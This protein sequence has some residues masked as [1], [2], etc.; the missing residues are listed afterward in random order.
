MSHHRPKVL[1]FG[2]YRIF[3]SLALWVIAPVANGQDIGPQNLPSQNSLSPAQPSS[4]PFD[5]DYMDARA[6]TLMQQSQ[7]TG[8]AMA[9][10]IDGQI[11]FAKGYGETLRGSGENVTA[12]TIFRWASISKSVAANI[13]LSLSEDGHFTLE[14]YAEPL[15][16]SLKLPKARDRINL[17]HLLSHQ[18]GLV[19]NANDVKIE[20]GLGAIE[21][22]QALQDL[23]YLCPPTQCHS[24]QNVTFDASA[25]ISER[26]TGKPYARLVKE[27]LFR[28]LA[29]QSASVG[30]QGLVKAKSWARPHNRFGIAF[31]KVKPNYYNL[32]AAAGV[33]SSVKD[34]AKWMI[35]HMPDHSKFPQSRLMA[36][37]HP[38]VATPR[39]Q[40]FMN[41][42]F[43]ALQMAHYGLGWRIYDYHGHKII[44]HRG[45]VQG[46]RSLA[47]F[48]PEKNAGIAMMWNSPHSRPI[49]LQIEFL[50]RLHKRP[51]R[52][53]MSFGY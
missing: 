3:L 24:Y 14:D 43:K 51:L 19:R 7:M 9:V 21:A 41:R 6:T 25:E 4:D 42:R 53:W 2:F 46:Y 36:L 15:A 47:L 50:D 32:P 31:S 17:L 1:F 8:M 37:H 5:I 52:D 26:V 49:G 22:R 28:P 11:V 40:R 12:D 13:L 39:E 23:P 38:Y 48:D 35:A 44:G 30:Y 16:P 18:I 33:N 34:L 27:R 45:G 10:V 29:M 20:D